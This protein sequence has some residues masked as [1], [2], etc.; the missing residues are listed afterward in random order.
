MVGVSTVSSIRDPLELRNR[1]I[2]ADVELVLLGLVFFCAFENF[3]NMHCSSDVYGN[4]G[5]CFLATTSFK[6]CKAS[7]FPLLP[8][9]PTAYPSQSP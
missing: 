5:G 7:S 2:T 3:G 8:P 9:V 1:H 6:T 4:L